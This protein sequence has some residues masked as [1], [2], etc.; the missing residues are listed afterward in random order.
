MGV[1]MTFVKQTGCIIFLVLLCLR[2]AHAEET[3]AYY[4]VDWSGLHVADM[5][6]RLD[7]TPT[8]YAMETIIKTSGMVGFFSS[9]ISYTTATGKRK[10][11]VY[12]PEKFL[13]HTMSRGKLT[14]TKMIYPGAG[15][16]P[17]RT[18]KEGAAEVTV[19]PEVPI[20]KRPP[21]PVED[22]IK[23]YDPIT[24][25]LAFRQEM[26]T[27]ATTP[28]SMNGY[29]GKRLYKME[30]TR[31]EKG[32]ALEGF[33]DPTRTA[34]VRRIPLKGY[35]DKELKRRSGGTTVMTAHVSEKAP[36][37]PA[38]ISGTVVGGEGYIRLKEFCPDLASCL[39]KAKI[40]VPPG[41]IP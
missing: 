17:I 22:Q 32:V 3:I 23:G 25:F 10:G 4:S 36:Y 15:K 31:G 9:F 30:G 39:A 14:G 35:S 26:L 20:G 8:R 37:A 41:L 38:L 13:N 18:D 24:L 19:G 16:P 40:T 1:T 5:V 12:E 7:E 21:V 34:A 29:D 2:T 11:T 28:I 27:D 6:V 33:P